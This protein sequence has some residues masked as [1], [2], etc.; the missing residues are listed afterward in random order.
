M[1]AIILGIVAAII[2]TILAKKYA[3]ASNEKFDALETTLAII[4]IGCFLIV[5]LVMDACAFA[6]YSGTVIETTDTPELVAS[7]DLVALQDNSSATGNFF[8]G[9]GSV[10]N[11][12]YYAFYYETGHGYKYETL[13]AESSS[14]P[15]YIKY[16]PA[17]ETPH[18]DQYAIVERQTLTADGSKSWLFSIIAWLNY[19]QYEPGGLISEEITSP[20]LFAPSNTPDYYDNFRYEIHIPEGSIKQGYEIDLE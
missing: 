16:I 10:S 14:R 19:H 9:S 17:G 3:K 6:I 12:S 1:I 11:K 15:V 8:L 20:A 18:I 2:I 5:F 13:D 4:A 7:A